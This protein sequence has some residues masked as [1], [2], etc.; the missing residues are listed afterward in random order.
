MPEAGKS[1]AFYT[2][3]KIRKAVA[4]HRFT[5]KFGGKTRE[6]TVSIGTTGFPE[7]RAVDKVIL[8][9]VEENLQ[10]AKREGK[11]QVWPVYHDTTVRRKR[12]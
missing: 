12:A 1:D 9:K 11:N 6:I 5:N 2:A 8:D 4:A 10:E 3:E 7:C